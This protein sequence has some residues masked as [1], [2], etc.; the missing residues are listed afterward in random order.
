MEKITFSLLV[1]NTPGVL[2]RIAGLFSRRAYNIESVTSGVTSNPGIF[3]MTIVSSVDKGNTDQIMAQ[4]EKLVDV[5]SIKILKPDNSVTHELMMVKVMAD[6]EARHHLISV[7]EIFHARIVDVQ[8][9]CLTF[10]LTG[11][12]AKLE[13]FLEMCSNYQ[14]AEIA[15]TGVTGL[16]RGSDGIKYL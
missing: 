12:Q 10:E 1:D 8:K 15:R 11:R 13:A 16:S 7:A 4:L 9:D 2:G 14:I 6:E 3:R 5:R